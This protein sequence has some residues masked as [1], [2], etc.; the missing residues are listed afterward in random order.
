MALLAS[1]LARQRGQMSGEVK[2]E[3]I[4]RRLMR[5]G[6]AIGCRG[7]CGRVKWEEQCVGGQ[8]RRLFDGNK[9]SSCLRAPC[10]T[11]RR[12]P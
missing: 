12:K 3:E 1:P 8:T 7:G 9:R 2:R 11:R 5:R 4:K 6:G 10:V